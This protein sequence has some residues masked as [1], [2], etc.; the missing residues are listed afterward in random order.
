[1][2]RKMAKVYYFSKKGEENMSTVQDVAKTFL[3]IE[4]M[5]HKKLQKLCYYAYCWYRTLYNDRSP[6]FDNRFEAWV[7]GPVDPI[8]YN[9]YRDS[10]WS[11]IPA[12]GNFTPDPEVQEFVSSVHKSYG[13]LD[14][15]EL[16]YLTHREAPWVI[17]RRGLPEGVPCKNPITDA[18]IVD[19]YRKVMENG[20]QD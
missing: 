19:F 5:T 9:E 8:L 16:E 13:H 10:G 6:L 14:G 2:V 7:H 11:L 3:T 17:A 20:Q 4:S 1:M 15:D 18:T 12:V